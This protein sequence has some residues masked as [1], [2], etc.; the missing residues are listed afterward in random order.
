[1][2]FFGPIN[3]ITYPTKNHINVSGLDEFSFEIIDLKGRVLSTDRNS[4]IIS[5]GDFTN[6][7]YVLNIENKG[8]SK[9]FFV[10][11]E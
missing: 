7:I 11:K 6:G 3:S 5:I 2:V 9:K 8:F 1:M 4:N 10:V